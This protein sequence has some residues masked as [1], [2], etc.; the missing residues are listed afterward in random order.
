MLVVLLASVTTSC[1]V[2]TDGDI[3]DRLACLATWYADADGDGFG[4]P[5]RAVESCTAPAFHAD[6]PDDCDDGDGTVNPGEVESW[7][8]GL[9]QDCDGWDD[10]DADRDGDPSEGHGGGDCDDG[11]P[12]V[13]SAAT[14][15]CEDRL[16][17][18]CDGLSGECGWGGDLDQSE[19]GLLTGSGLGD[20]TGISIIPATDID[21]DGYHDLLV[22]SYKAEVRPGV[23]AGVVSLVEGPVVDTADIQDSSRTFYLGEFDDD[24][25][26][27]DLTRLGD[28]TG[29]G[30]A[31]FGIG[32]ERYPGLGVRGGALHVASTEAVGEVQLGTGGISL[33][34]EPYHR[35]GRAVDSAGDAD[36]DGHTDALLGCPGYG[37]P[38]STGAAWVA[39][40]PITATT[41]IH[42]ADT[43]LIEGA[44][45]EE[46]LGWAVSSA[47]LDGDGRTDF[48]LGAPAQS[49]GVGTAYVIHGPRFA[50]LLATDG[51]ALTGGEDDRCGSSLAIDDFDGD[52]TRDVAVG[53]PLA[54]NALEDSGQVS[55]VQGPIEDPIALDE[56][57]LQLL[58]EPFDSRA[59]T[60]LAAG[61]ADDDGQVD[62]LV[63]AEGYD[64]LRGRVYLWIGPLTGVVAL[65]DS[66]AAF[67]GVEAGDHLGQDVA[68]LGDIDA[69]GWPDFGL[70]AWGRDDEAGAVYVMSGGVGF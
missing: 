18:D 25:T 59:G 64:E 33:I 62:L 67:D 15:V 22:A 45:G 17:N 7:Y 63:G 49:G 23:R 68:F 26:G 60:S 21:G 16:D 37:Y 14:E 10:Y 32:A 9:D 44:V 20:R 36:G 52:G 19:S 70:G 31:D 6:N 56:A 66:D 13:Y 55:V 46:D 51:V 47:D 42:D 24:R 1:L 28:F 34:A 30:V 48:V 4:D 3:E 38:A 61:D 53:C 43:V 35:L 50:P 5:E 8:D 39:Y 40:G 69:D 27:R 12:A 29:D 58:G 57:P 41:P 11:E 2:V 65:P 54:D